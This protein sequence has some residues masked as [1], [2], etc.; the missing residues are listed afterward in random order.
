M[1][2]MLKYTQFSIMENPVY[3]LKMKSIFL[4]NILLTYQ[5]KLL[6]SMSYTDTHFKA[7]IKYIHYKGI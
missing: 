2:I 1:I 6:L 7:Y 5:I 4:E 3:F